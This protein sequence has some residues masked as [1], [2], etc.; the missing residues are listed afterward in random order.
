MPCDLLHL[1][2][3]DLTGAGLDDRN[4]VL[5]ALLAAAGAAADPVRYS[6]HVIGSG[7]DVFE[8]ACRLGLEGIIS[9]RRDAPYRGARG[10][11]WQKVKCL[12]RQEVVIGGYTDPEGSRATVSPVYAGR[13]HRVHRPQPAG[14]EDVSRARAGREAFETRRPRGGT[15]GEG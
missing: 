12:K 15:L 3:R 7:A 9:K 1:D 10:P 6:D 13:S 5:E 11:E 2:G 8:H 4:R 14:P